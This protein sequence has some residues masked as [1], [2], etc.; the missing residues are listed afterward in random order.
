MI[1]T[2]LYL[3][4]LCEPK[5]KKTWVKKLVLEKLITNNETSNSVT[6]LSQISQSNKS[7]EEVGF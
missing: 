7:Q 6:P 3:F 2:S 4:G 1:S 5:K